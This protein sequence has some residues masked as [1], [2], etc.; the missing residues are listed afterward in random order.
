[1]L[2]SSGF[3]CLLQVINFLKALLLGALSVV[4]QRN[5][6]LADESDYFVG[7][8]CRALVLNESNNLQS[9]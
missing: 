3:S 4:A 6:L 9:H 5:H 8:N 7:S 2:K 1:M